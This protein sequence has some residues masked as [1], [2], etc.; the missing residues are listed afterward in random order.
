MWV[1]EIERAVFGM[2]VQKIM[3]SINNT[4]MITFIPVLA[5]F[6][7]KLYDIAWLWPLITFQEGVE[8]KNTGSTHI[9]KK[10]RKSYADKSMLY[11][12]FV[13]VKNIHEI[14]FLLSFSYAVCDIEITCTLT[15]CLS[16]SLWHFYIILFNFRS[17]S[18]RSLKL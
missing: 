6:T 15:L 12:Q 17:V 2:L 10:K 18:E 3:S 9:S 16:V 4:W 7:S 1:A 5:T 8:I 14:I 13:K 11:G